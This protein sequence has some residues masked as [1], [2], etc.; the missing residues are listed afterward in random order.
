MPKLYDASD[1][2]LGIA[3]LLLGDQT[4]AV[5]RVASVDPALTA[6]IEAILPLHERLCPRQ[7]LGVRIA[8]QGGRL[9]GLRLPQAIG[10]KRLLTFVETDGCFVDG[11]AAA[12]GCSV[13]QRTMR[14]VDQGKVAVTFVDTVTE[15]A[16]RVWPQQ[17][18]RATALAYAPATTADRWLAQREGY[19]CMP[20]V[21]VG[22]KGHR[23]GSDHRGMKARSR[24]MLGVAECEEV[25]LPQWCC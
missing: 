15:H 10:Q 18:A 21:N 2:A 12:T 3:A 8:L 5:A 23:L 6:I 14:I 24:G 16:T 19:L 9:L 17:K 4:S 22:I 11:V 25:G 7:V 20:V 1:V 13:G